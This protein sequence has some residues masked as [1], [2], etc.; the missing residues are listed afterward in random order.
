MKRRK[1]ASGRR[2]FLLMEVIL[3]LGIFGM[4]ATG[5]AMALA[6]TADAAAMAQQ[7]MKIARILDSALTE[8]LSLPVLEEGTTSVVLKED[9]IEVDTRVELI[10]DLQNLDGKILQEMYRIEV[11]AHWY[12]FGEWVE[13]TA[14][15]WR[16]SRLYVP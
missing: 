8:A 9:G 4:A 15:T 3:A 10:E 7:R 2:G 11:S 5:F 13:E 14:E 1:S 16:Y 12:E 6:K